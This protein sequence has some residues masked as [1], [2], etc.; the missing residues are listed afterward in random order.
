MALKDD[1]ATYTVSAVLYRIR[2]QENDGGKVRWTA[3]A[4][5]NQL[6]EPVGSA[7]LDSS[8]LIADAKLHLIGA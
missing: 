7:W 2:R 3:E 8:Y 4:L 5:I 6:W 1:S